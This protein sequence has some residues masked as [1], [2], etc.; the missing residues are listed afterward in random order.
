MNR[1]EV[2][3][4]LEEVLQNQKDFIEECTAKAVKTATESI[5]AKQS[6]QIKSIENK[7]S[8]KSHLDRISLSKP[9]NQRQLEA[10][11]EIMDHLDKAIEEI[12]KGKQAEAKATLETGKKLVSK[13]IK[14][15]R[16]ADRNGWDVAK[17]YVSDDLA[18]DSEDDKEIRKAIRAASTKS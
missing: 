11:R 5:L 4:V 15:I 6:D 17:E 14:L 7:L 12:E 2:K 9:G 10:N 8:S 18:S 3:S 16:L 1:E 13:R